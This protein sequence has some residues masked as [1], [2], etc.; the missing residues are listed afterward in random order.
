MLANIRI[1]LVQPSHTGNIGAVARAMLNMGLSELSLINP[2]VMPDDHS[3]AMASHATTIIEQ[4]E[5]FDSLQQAIADCDWVIGTSA[6]V[7]RVS[8][9][10]ISAGQAGAHAVKNASQ[11]QR[12]AIVFGRERTGLFN[13]EL[14]MCHQHAYI[15]S[16]EAYCSLNLAQAVQI[17][18]YEVRRAYESASEKASI[19]QSP[20]NQALA[21]NQAS[22]AQMQGLYQHFE[23]AM[24]VSGFLSED[25]KDRGVVEKVQR[26]F[27]ARPLAKQEVNILRGFLSQ[28][29]YL[30]ETRNNHDS[31]D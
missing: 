24:N 3:R 26:I 10:L 9:P 27:Q 2:K 6:R 20:Y 29:V 23:H 25:K 17:F 14:L 8:L 4:A 28:V 16:N 11:G 18:C 22:V 7:R 13:Q 12:I 21:K 5:V 31:R 15:P 1:V 30:A 19:P